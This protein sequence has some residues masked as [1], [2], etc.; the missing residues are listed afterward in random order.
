VLSTAS[1][2]AAHAQQRIN[3][4]GAIARGVVTIA[5]AVTALALGAAVASGETLPASCTTLQSEITTASASKGVDTVV[6]TEMCKETVTLP[7]KAEFTLEGASGT[8]SGLDGE[9]L[10]GPLLETTEAGGAMTISNMTFE[11]ATSHAFVGGALELFDSSLALN[12]DRFVDDTV[13]EAEAGGAGAY[14]VIIPANGDACAAHEPPALTVTDSSFI[15]DTAKAGNGTLPSH[16]GGLYAILECGGRASY[17][18][19]DSFEGDSVTTTGSAEAEGGGASLIDPAASPGLLYQEGNVFDSDTVVGPAEG[20]RGGGGEWLEGINL[21]SVGDRFSRDSIPGTSGSKWSWGAGLGILNTSCDATNPTESTLE[22]AVVAGNSIAAGTP[23]DLGGAGIY[24]G[25]ACGPEPEH[26]SH[27]R[28]LDSTV[29]ENS[30]AT[31]GG[32][33]GIDGHPSDQLTI[34][35]RLSRQTAAARRSAA[36]PARAAC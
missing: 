3:A 6:L 5:L 14:V 1:R 11:H 15:E 12:G 10:A 16:G 8:T 28:L 31:P 30:V 2:G 4:V 13:E 9:G 32:V 17:L 36:S 27:L 20:N 25:V 26:H 7:A 19:H 33:A 24:V 35:T 29:T 21:T 34:E 18:D 23:A 22:D